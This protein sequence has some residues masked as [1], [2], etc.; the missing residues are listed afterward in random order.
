MWSC[1][2]SQAYQQMR[3][4]PLNWC[5][6]GIMVD[7]KYYI[8]L[9]PSSGCRPS[10]AACQCMMLAVCWIMHQ[11]GFNALVYI[12]DI[13]GIEA[14]QERAR[15]A[16]AFFL[17]LCDKLGLVLAPDKCVAPTT[18]L[19]WLGIILDSIMF[20]LTMPTQKLQEVFNT[21]TMWL[22]RQW[23]HC[24][25]LQSVIGRLMRLCK[26]L[27][28]SRKFLGRLIATLCTA[29]DGKRSFLTPGTRADLAWFAKYAEST[30]G[31]YLAPVQQAV[32]H[33]TCLCLEDGLIAFSSTAWMTAALPVRTW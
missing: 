4:C 23:I 18:C 11:H 22:N 2:L 32:V 15:E 17:A 14:T 25:Q 26:C 31:V 30:N 3:I 9:C 28:A 19:Q 7:G 33:F 16:Y 24:C 1:D 27:P 8:D 13:V 21:C 20:T 12:D 10:G 29:K 6:L 5:L